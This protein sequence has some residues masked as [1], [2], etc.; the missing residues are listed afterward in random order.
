MSLF[1][2]IFAVTFFDII[3]EAD[4]ALRHEIELNYTIGVEALYSGLDARITVLFILLDLVY[5]DIE[6][7]KKMKE[8]SSGD[9]KDSFSK[10]NSFKIDENWVP[11]SGLGGGNA[12]IEFNEERTYELG[13]KP[14]L[15]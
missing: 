9:S 10:Q 15:V 1:S 13:L 11:I 5:R 4:E 8:L 2:E 6:T 12:K 7:H 14:F 3:D